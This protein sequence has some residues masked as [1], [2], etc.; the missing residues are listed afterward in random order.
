MQHDAMPDT[1]HRF[2][3]GR[4]V[5]ETDGRVRYLIGWVVLLLVGIVALHGGSA[6]HAQ[7]TAVPL[8]STVSSPDSANVPAAVWDLVLDGTAEDWPIAPPTARPESL[9]TV[10]RTLLRHIRRNGHYYARIDSAVAVP[11]SNGPPRVTLYGHRGPRITVDSLRIE[12]D[13]TLPAAAI[14]RLLNTR[15]GQPLDADRLESD[16]AALLRAYDAEGRPL[17]Q[18]Q[19]A[20]M[21]LHP[22]SPP[23]L[24]V[25]LR[26]DAGPRLWLKRI[27]TPPNVRTAPDLLAHLADL[28]VGARLHNYDP[29]QLREQLERSDLF[30]SVDAPSLAVDAEGGATLLLPVNETTPGTFDAVLGYL[31]PSGGRSSGQLVGSG[32]LSLRNVFGGGRTGDIELDR[33][34]GQ[35]SLFEATVADPYVLNRPLRLEG[36]FRGE[37]R[38]STFGTRRFR[39]GVGVRLDR[40]FRVSGTLTRERT[41]PGQAGTVL[42][43]TDGGRLRQQIPR[44]EV[45]F[46]GIGL[47]YERMDRPVNPRSGGWMDVTVEQGTKDR[48]RRVVSEGDTTRTQTSERQERLQ[49]AGRFFVPVQSRQVLVVGGEASV[50]RSDDFD[51][52]DLFRIGGASSLRGYDE[53][54]FT[55]NIVAR[56]LVEYRLQVGR[57]SYAF[58]FGDLGYVQ[59]PAIDRIEASSGWHPGFGIGIQFDTALGLVQASY[60]LSTEEATPINGR[61][62]LG[63]SVGL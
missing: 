22:G 12:S 37:Q 29:E 53:D 43:S 39:L 60:A 50:L 55:G 61:V 38:D 24:A 17:A 36:H 35:V 14:R 63:L 54:R 52:S 31:P 45:L 19:V 58:A 59:R 32:H 28:D 30:Q 42:V 51:S 56:L 47:R 18:V 23:T 46:F 8:D 26:I 11:S 7:P 44:A 16:I 13:S 10:S 9:A 33:R 49:V 34:P 48:S 21:R 27:V 41:R 3:G 20:D 5:R 2:D 4:S 62:H 57:R 6:T 40:A 25:T 15:E 1:N